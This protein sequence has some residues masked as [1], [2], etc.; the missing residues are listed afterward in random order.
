MSSNK[1]N[2]WNTIV[3][4]APENMAWESNAKFYF[5]GTP[6]AMLFS[7]KKVDNKETE[8]VKA[9]VKLQNDGPNHVAVYNDKLHSI[10]K[11]LPGKKEESEDCYAFLGLVDG[12]E[13]IVYIN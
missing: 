4:F 11:H 12:D 1:A 2:P 5:Y 10:A 3:L 8:I 6:D 7:K 9:Y 13:V